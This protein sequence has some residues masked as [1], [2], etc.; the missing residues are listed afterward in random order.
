MHYFILQNNIV[1]LD[2]KC[3]HIT[4]VS[5]AI[6]GK[7]LFIR[8]GDYVCSNLSLYSLELKQYKFLY[9]NNIK[10]I[11]NGFCDEFPNAISLA[12]SVNQ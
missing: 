4:F 8:T 5:C 9:L 1:T 6:F 2:N 11:K 12:E 10:L 7:N 3:T